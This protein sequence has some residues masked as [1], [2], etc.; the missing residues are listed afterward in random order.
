MDHRGMLELARDP[1]RVRALAISLKERLGSEI[2]AK[3]FDFLTKLE[4]YSDKDFLSGGHREFLWS[5]IQQA[6]RSSK[7]GPYR[8]DRLVRML[9]E[10]RLDLTEEEEVYVIEL[11]ERG[12]G[13]MLSHA[14]WR[15]IFR[16][17]RER[18]DI[19]DDYIPLR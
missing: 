13:L 15:W 8:A 5:L 10:A 19:G 4:R 1:V 7:Q 2:N 14:E 3:A 6:S 11:H 12:H 9:W 17:C 18:G 16:L